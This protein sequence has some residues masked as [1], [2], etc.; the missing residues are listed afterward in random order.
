MFYDTSY[1]FREM[2]LIWL[3]V[4]GVWGLSLVL[5]LKMA[6]IE[7]SALQQVVVIQQADKAARKQ[8]LIQV[9]SGKAQINGK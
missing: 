4:I 8:R 9:P 7:L 5:A 6:H 1:T 2:A 3:V